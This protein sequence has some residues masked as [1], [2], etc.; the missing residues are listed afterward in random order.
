MYCFYVCAAKSWILLNQI[1]F[2]KTKVGKDFRSLSTYF[3]REFNVV[4][5]KKSEK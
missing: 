3:H 4:L 1:D 2:F 5:L